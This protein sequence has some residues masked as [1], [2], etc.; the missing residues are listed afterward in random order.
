[1]GQQG[2]L[3]PFD[4]T[5]ITPRQPGVFTLADLVQRLVQVPQHVKLVVQDAGL[6]RMARLER[7]VAERLPHIHHREADFTAFSRP[8][9]RKEQVHALLGAVV[10]A[11]PDRPSAQQ[12]ADHNPIRVS[13]ADGDLIDADDAGRR[14]ARTPQLLAHVLH[15]KGLDR[16]PVEMEFAGHIANGRA[17]AAA[18]DI[19]GKAFGVERVVRQPGQF[20]LLHGVAPAAVHA[21]DLDLQ[22]DAC[23]ATGQVANAPQLA[24]VEAPLK[25]SADAAGRF[26]RRRRRLTTRAL[27]R[28]RCRGQSAPGRSRG[29]DRRPAGAGVFASR[30]HDTFPRGRKCKNPRKNGEKSHD[31]GRKL[32]TRFGEEPFGLFSKACG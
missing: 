23:I 28:R 16:L 8:Q 27:G 17:A 32:P 2:V 1:M 21:S 30:N 19:E 5:A 18:A 24:V 26:F 15:F 4:E 10:T 11:E 3:L 25:S 22:V 7:R 9:P 14:R 13:L 29:S 31:Q 20:F 6:R 12:I